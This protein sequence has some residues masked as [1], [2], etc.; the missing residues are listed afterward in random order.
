MLPKVPH[1]RVNSGR[2][3]GS[4]VGVTGEDEASAAEIELVKDWSAGGIF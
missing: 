2:T 1:V 4:D 3:A